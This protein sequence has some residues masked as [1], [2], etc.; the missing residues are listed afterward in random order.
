MGLRE[1]L[2]GH[3]YLDPVARLAGEVEATACAAVAT[4][5]AAVPDWDAYRD[6]YRAGVP[7]LESPSVAIDLAPAEALLAAVIPEGQR[8]GFERTAGW[9]VVA[10]WLAPVLREFATWRDEDAWLRPHCPVCGSAPAM[11]QLAGVDPGRMRFLVCGACRTRWRYSRTA[12][13]FCE[14]DV[15]R[16]NVLAAE[17]EKGLRLDVCEG[18]NGY[19]KTYDGEGDEDVLL[20]DWTSLHL[21]VLAHDHGLKRFAASLYDLD[22][23]LSP[24]TPG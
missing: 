2:E 15:Q 18:C 14:R 6:E 13:P 17:G 9:A 4:P 21:D 24:P 1:W 3:P 12:C 5:C 23:L 19:L 10:R 16:L 20:L 22:P 8:P 11:A 7:L